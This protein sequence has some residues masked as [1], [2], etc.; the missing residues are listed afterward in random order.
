[1]TQVGS[2]RGQLA[3]TEQSCGRDA[4]AVRELEDGRRLERRGRR[5]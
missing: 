4:G 2:L 3:V 5:H 1:M